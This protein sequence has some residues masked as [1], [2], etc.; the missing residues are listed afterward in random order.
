MLPP[1]EESLYYEQV[2]KIYEDSKKRFC[3]LGA[4]IIEEDD[5]ESWT[6]D[7]LGQEFIALIS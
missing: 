3:Y 6:N 5:I 1:K 4:E 2:K 7:L